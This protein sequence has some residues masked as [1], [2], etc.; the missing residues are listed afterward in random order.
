MNTSIEILA[1]REMGQ[2]PVSIGTSLALESV[3]GIL[4]E[5]E[6]DDPDIHKF[7]SLW[8]NVRTL[9]RN[10]VASIPSDQK[11]M[12]SPEDERD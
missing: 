9:F 12:L 7:D 11:V 3:T 6:T 5:H 2:L 4:P 10:I 1:G 8:V